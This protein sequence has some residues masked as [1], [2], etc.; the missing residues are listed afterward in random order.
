MSAYGATCIQA[1][2]I[3]RVRIANERRGTVAA[4]YEGEIPGSFH[5]V[6]DAHG[7]RLVVRGIAVKE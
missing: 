2:S 1:V 6:E 5:I 4:K 3:I 7:S